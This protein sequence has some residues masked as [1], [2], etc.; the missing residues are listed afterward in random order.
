M[1]IDPDF[2]QDA[3]YWSFNNS[4]LADMDVNDTAKIQVFQS[5]GASQLDIGTASYFSGYLVC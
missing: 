2:G 1:I 4:V 5:S 3:A